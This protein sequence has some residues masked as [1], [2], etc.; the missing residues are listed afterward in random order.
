MF[1]ITQNKGVHLT[2]KNGW[3]ISIQWGYGNYCKNYN[4]SKLCTL[5]LVMGPETPRSL[6]SNDAE[7]AIFTQNLA[8]PWV[9][10][11]DDIVKG[12]LSS[13]EVADLI[14]ITQH[15]LP[16]SELEKTPKGK[17]PISP[18]CKCKFPTYLIKW[19]GEKVIITLKN[20]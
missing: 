3:V 19:N 5:G 1:Q 10:F 4:V 6:S 18:D 7:V 16:V 20:K 8:F 13:D 2:F 17:S 14:S 15:L 9:S 12:W 11:G